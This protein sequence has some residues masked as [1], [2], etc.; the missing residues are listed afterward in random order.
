MVSQM[1]KEDWKALAGEGIILSFEQVCDLNALGLAV[2]RGPYAGEVYAGPRIGW[3]G[4]VPIHEPT[5]QSEQWYI[6]CACDWWT[7]Q[8]LFWSL[9]WACAHAPRRGWFERW[10]TEGH[11]RAAVELWA[12]RLP[13]TAAQLS[14]AL[15]YAIRGAD[16]AP[17]DPES[18]QD[19]PEGPPPCPHSGLIDDALAAG[20]GLTHARVA[21]MPRRRVVGI[22]RRWAENQIAAVGGKADFDKGAKTDAYVRYDDYLMAVR[23]AALNK[24][25]Q[26]YG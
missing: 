11:A 16:V 17:R 23:E 5:I 13:C 19:A 22:L 20:L 2:E 6:G 8:S 9:A 4:S 25:A 14:T 26:V 12:N 1:A 3:A 24:G 21:A 18:A 15:D 7:G 10:Q